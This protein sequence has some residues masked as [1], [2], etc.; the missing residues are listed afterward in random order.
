MGA[1]CLEIGF[2]DRMRVRADL[3]REVEHGALARRDIC[4]EVVHRDLI[5]HERLFS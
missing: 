4:L 5:G 3:H 2:A 1:Q